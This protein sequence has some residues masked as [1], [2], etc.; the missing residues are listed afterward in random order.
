MIIPFKFDIIKY[1]AVC[2]TAKWRIDTK[3]RYVKK[4]IRDVDKFNDSILKKKN[5][6]C[7]ISRLEN[8]CF[9]LVLIKYLQQSKTKRIAF[10]FDII[11]VVSTT[12]NTDKWRIDTRM[13]R[14]KESIKYVEMFNDYK[15]KNFNFKCF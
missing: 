14:V 4:S 2:I 6:C 8:K 15:I 7:N 10:K 12:I 5:P 13:R 9:D 3:T 1:V 11:N